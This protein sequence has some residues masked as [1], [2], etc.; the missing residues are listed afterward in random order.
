MSQ[1]SDAVQFEPFRSA[2]DPTFWS[3][4]SSRKIE[5]DKL[6]ERS[7]VIRGQFSTSAR[8]SIPPRLLL[9]GDFSYAP[10]AKYVIF[11]LVSL[12]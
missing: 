3:V 5:V 10:N 7:S 2:A 1:T 8:D 4:F 12:V 11:L 9:S 6:D